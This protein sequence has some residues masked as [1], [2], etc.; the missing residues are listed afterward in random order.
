MPTIGQMERIQR[1]EQARVFHAKVSGTNHCNVH[2]PLPHL[3]PT[4]PCE[5]ICISLMSITMKY[6]LGCVLG[7]TMKTFN[8]PKFTTVSTTLFFTYSTLDAHL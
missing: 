6:Y 5:V 8:S 3:I 7:G 4:L 1:G 2:Y